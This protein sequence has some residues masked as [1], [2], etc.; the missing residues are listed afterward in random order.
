MKT[1]TLLLT[2]FKTN[3]IGAVLQAYALYKVLNRHSDVT[4]LDL[5][6]GHINSGLKLIRFSI[7][8]KSVLSAGKDLMRINSRKKI[9]T[10]FDFFK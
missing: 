10:K 2:I 4:L 6:N 8:I 5:K 3:N 9:I 1:K 7:T